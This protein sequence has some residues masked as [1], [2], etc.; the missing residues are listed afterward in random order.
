MGCS[1]PDA[2]PLRERLRRRL[3]VASTNPFDLLTAAGRDCVGAVQLLP[4]GEPPTGFDQIRGVA[5]SARVSRDLL[6]AS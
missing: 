4:D 3:D 5:L 6:G 2:R 1:T